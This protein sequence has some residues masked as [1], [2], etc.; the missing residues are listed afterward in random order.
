MLY[1]AQLH[2]HTSLEKRVLI[3]FHAFATVFPFFLY[4]YTYSLFL[5]TSVYWTGYSTPLLCI[6]SYIFL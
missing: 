6:V 1:K 5:H 3:S 2:F 4:I